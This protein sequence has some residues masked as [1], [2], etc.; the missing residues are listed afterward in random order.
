MKHNK[1]S[2]KSW[3]VI[4]VQWEIILIYFPIISCHYVYGLLILLFFLEDEASSLGPEIF[5]ISFSVP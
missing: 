2:R 1:A 4:D 3:S 5:F